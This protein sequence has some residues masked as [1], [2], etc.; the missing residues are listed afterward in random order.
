MPSLVISTL[1]GVP[2]VDHEFFEAKTRVLVSLTSTYPWGASGV[3][4]ESDTVNASS[5]LVNSGVVTVGGHSL[6]FANFFTGPGAAPNVKLC[7]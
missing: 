7:K 2:Y 4:T 6:G 3:A 5:H 1:L